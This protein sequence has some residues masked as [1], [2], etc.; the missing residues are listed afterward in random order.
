MP[1]C[2]TCAAALLAACAASAVELPAQT[3]DSVDLVGLW[4]AKRRFGPDA[5]GPLL[6]ARTGPG[7][8]ADMMG[9]T[10]PVRASGGE[11]TFALP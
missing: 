8:T 2:L 11:L 5:R 9:F 7:Y 1:R 4:K 10:V 3:A 6:I